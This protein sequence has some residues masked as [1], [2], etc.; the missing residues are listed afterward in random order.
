MN[1]PDSPET[2]TSMSEAAPPEADTEGAPSAAAGKPLR[3]F[4]AIPL[5]DL[6]RAEVDRLATRLRKGF[7]FT[8]CRPTWVR[9]EN[10]HVTLAFLGSTPPERLPELKAKFAAAIVPG[11]EPIR[12]EL[13]ELGVFP[14]WKRPNVLWTRVSETGDRLGPLRE[15]VAAAACELGYESETRPFRPHLTLA[16]FKSPKGVDA[17]RDKVESHRSFRGTP[18]EATE[19]V[20]FASETDPSGPCYTRLESFPL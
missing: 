7:A 2:E 18:F 4:V 8:S 5:P 10:L 11:G 19:A 16:R 17:A 14:D 6:V 3:L 9:P 15:S 13:R 20:L 12:L 1:P